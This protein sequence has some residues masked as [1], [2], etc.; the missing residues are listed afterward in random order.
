ML[1]ILG[2]LNSYSIEPGLR[3]KL[4]STG[5]GPSS[6]LVPKLLLG[7]ALGSQALPG[8]NNFTPDL[9]RECKAELCIHR[10]SQAG[11]WE[12]ETGRCCFLPL[13]GNDEPGG[14]GE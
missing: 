13:V 10:G 6:H 2:I 9:P 4:G 8:L 5:V 14:E 12:P 3:P 7:D 11:A 1:K